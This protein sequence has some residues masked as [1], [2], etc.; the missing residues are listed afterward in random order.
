MP[1]RA[2]RSRNSTS[3]RSGAS[4]SSAGISVASTESGLPV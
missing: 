1:A 3:A 4:A 2:L